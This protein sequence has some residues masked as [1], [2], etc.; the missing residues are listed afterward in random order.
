MT[1]TDLYDGAEAEG[2][3]PMP[4]ER[5]GGRRWVVVGVAVL[6]LGLLTAGLGAAWFQSQLDPAGAPG[7]PVTFTVPEGASASSIADLL[8]EEGVI[9]N[10]TAF[11]FY[12]R[13]KGV[14]GF[15]AGE[16]TLRQDESADAVI[17]ALTA[18]PKFVFKGNKL[19]IPEGFTL[20]QI[21]ARVGKV[22]GLSAERFLELAN[23]GEVRSQYQPDDSNNMEGLLYPETYLI[24]DGEDERSILTKM[25]DTFDAQAAASGIDNAADQVG[26]TP[27]EAIV[28]ASLIERETRFD[29]ER[30]KVSRVIQNRLAKKM[31]LEIDATVVYALGGDKTRVLLKDL[32]VDSPYNTYK[33]SG[34]PPTPIA[35]PS[36]ASMEAAVAPVD[37]PWLFYVVTEADGRHSFSE[38]FAEQQRNIRLAE[39]RGLR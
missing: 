21:A 16:Y 12:V 22:P 25:V 29:E 20:K 11:R 39:Q 35:S 4:P 14:S 33:I 19:T 3:E 38:T 1:A 31:R 24:E 32:Q 28:A 10:A 26:L 34:L 2:W 30:G 27:Y 23:S 37:G 7:D 13:F 9:R 17:A 36:R 8:E 18:G 6:V 15:K 5:K